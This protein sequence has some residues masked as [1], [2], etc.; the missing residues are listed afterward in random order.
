[1]IG[2]HPHVL[3]GIEYYEGKPIFYSLGNFIF[4]QN[5]DSTVAVRFTISGDSMQT[6]LIPATASG[7]KTSL[8]ND[9]KKES[10]YTYL[11][12]ISSTVQIDE[13]GK[14]DEK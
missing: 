5:I 11:E 14:L 3:Q 10:I 13:N 1:V 8:A 12:S 9:S 7:A 2:A 4:N 6:Q